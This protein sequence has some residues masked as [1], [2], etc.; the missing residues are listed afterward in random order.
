MLSRF[1]SATGAIEEANPAVKAAADL[2]G[3]VYRASK[4]PNE[5]QKRQNHMKS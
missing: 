3:G 5:A 2:D 4:Q 1:K